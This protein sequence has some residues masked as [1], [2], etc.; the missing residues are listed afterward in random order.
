MVGAL[1]RKG[2]IM[3]QG[4]C[5]TS[6]EYNDPTLPPQNRR[7]V[8][9]QGNGFKMRL[10]E[11]D[12][13]SIPVDANG[14]E[15]PPAKVKHVIISNGFSGRVELSHLANWAEV[16]LRVRCENGGMSDPVTVRK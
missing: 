6:A 3:T 16:R 13:V 5:L 1:F 11:D 15:Q 4:R 10:T 9:F 2:N 8:F 7:I 14:R 12:V